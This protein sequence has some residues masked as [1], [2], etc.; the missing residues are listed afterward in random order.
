MS[1]PPQRTDPRHSAAT[2]LPPV[3]S[4]TRLLLPS[5][6]LWDRDEAWSAAP[7]SRRG[8]NK[9]PTPAPYAFGECIDEPERVSV[10]FAFVSKCEP[11]A[12]AFRLINMRSGGSRCI[13]HS[14]RDNVSAIGLIRLG[15]S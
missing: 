1:R 13:T 5:A 10:R 14:P 6:A 4:V 8:C 9:A 12:S 11:D 3:T 15:S 7:L 2:P